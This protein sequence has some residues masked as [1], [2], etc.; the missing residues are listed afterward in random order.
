V[1][2]ATK[3][4]EL[5][6]RYFELAPQ[7]DTGAYFA[8]FAADATVEDEGKQ[9]HG[10]EAIRGW[11]S[12]VPRVTYTVHEVRRN[13]GGYD[14]A[15]DIA[16]GFPRQSRAPHLPLRINRQRPYPA[17]HHPPLK[18]AR[19]RTRSPAQGLCRGRRRAGRHPRQSRRALQAPG[20]IKQS[21]IIPPIIDCS[22]PDPFA[23]T[24]PPALAP[25]GPARRG[26]MVPGARDGRDAR[27]AGDGP[28][29]GAA[30]IPR[31]RARQGRPGLASM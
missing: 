30:S 15:L 21:Q 2:E 10:I 25:D 5:I 26:A 13:D 16:G 8:Q 9:H 29:A 23:P 4:P 27:R 6:R 28:R 22:V 18:A 17:A 7:P 31:M 3:A 19:P 1:T 12:E 11:R 20:S 24:V 14:A